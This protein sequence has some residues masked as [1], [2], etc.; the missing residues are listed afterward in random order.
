[1]E[2]RDVEGPTPLLLSDREKRVLELHDK[3]EQLQLEIALLNAQKNYVYNTTSGRTIEVA[4]QELLDSRARYMLRN[5]VVE[6]VVSANPILQAVHNGT[7]ASPIERD[8]LP[9]LTDRD[10]A[11]SALASQNT[12]LHSL[13][14][15]LMDV[16]SRS[17]RLSHENVTLAERLLDL[18]KQTEQGKAELLPSDS[19]HAAEIAEL[20]AE[21]KSSRQR[22]RVL[23]GTASAI[24]AGSGADWARDTELRDIVLDPAEEDV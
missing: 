14:S 13:L 4:Q 9:L 24:V 17:L 1:M 3:L 20:E 6:S 15:D 19:E 10:A 7:K 5:A 2:D 8:L 18:A 22:W 12:E 23:K 11:S 21:V 16:E